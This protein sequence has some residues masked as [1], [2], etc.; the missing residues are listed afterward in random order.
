MSEYSSVAVNCW[1]GDTFH[2]VHYGWTD[3]D[4]HQVGNCRTEGH[5]VVCTSER[6]EN[7]TEQTTKIISFYSS[8]L[9]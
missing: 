8:Q 1:L 2:M 5:L 4:Q 7:M 6:N 3:S 9:R